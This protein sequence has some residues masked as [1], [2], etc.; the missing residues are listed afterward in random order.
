[1]HFGSSVFVRVTNPVFDYDQGNKLESL[2]RCIIDSVFSAV[3][4][5]HELQ[6][7]F[8]QVPYFYVVLAFR[9]F[10]ILFSD[11]LVHEIARF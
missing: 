11:F 5:Q 7:R 6:L 9:C 8:W 3:R 1:M 2:M 4:C 10:K